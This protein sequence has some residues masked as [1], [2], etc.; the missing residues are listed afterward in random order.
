MMS[1]NMVIEQL[2]R[3]LAEIDES[4]CNIVEV[5]LLQGIWEDLSYGEI[6]SKGG[7]SSEYLANVAAPR[8]YRK[9]SK[10]INKKVTKKNCRSLVEAHLSFVNSNKSLCYPS[11]AVPLNSP[12]YIERQ[13]IEQSACE[14][15]QKPGALIRIKAAKA[16]GKTSLLLRI[17]SYA[18][19]CGYRQIKFNLAQIDRA[20]LGNLDR[21]LRF[22]CANATQQLGLESKL[23]EYWDDDVG[24]K[25]SCSLY[26]RGYLLRQIDSPVVLAFDEL[27]RIFEYPQVAKDFLPLLRSW[28]EEAKINSIWKQ[29]RQIVVHS[30][31][32]Y[33]PLNINQS[34][35]NIGLPIQLSKFQ[36]CQVKELAQKYQINWHSSRELEQLVSLVGGHPAL[37]Q[38]A[39]YYLSRQ[40]ITLSELLKT[41]S[42]PNG[43]Y[44]NHLRHLWLILQAEPELADC[45][46][47]LLKSNLPERLKPVTAY[48][49]ASMGLIEQIGDEAVISCEL[50]RCYF[51][52]NFDENRLPVKC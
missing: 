33:I 24:S 8:L 20:I 1:L 46:K 5:I 45:C 40:E 12:L 47:L 34:P 16:M 15:I 49:L 36:L 9:L 48:K 17:L 42:T 7:Y 26:F 38:I 6:G 39:L 30:T 14:E 28:Y 51:A 10:L 37:I 50:Y 22:I 4:L 29:L 31:E 32:V 43:I 21:F 2:D 52:K 11:G 3:Q 19:I 18:D 23:E 13:A 27:N 35:F 25:V 44:H 41:A